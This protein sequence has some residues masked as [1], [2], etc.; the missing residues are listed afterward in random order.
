MATILNDIWITLDQAE[1]RAHLPQTAD[2]ADPDLL[3][4][5]LDAFHQA[6]QAQGVFETIGPELSPLPLGQADS[7]AVAVAATLGPE[8]DKLEDRPWMK[9]VLM[10]GL[11]QLEA[12]LN[13]RIKKRLALRNLFL[14]QPV[15][16]GGPA[17]PELTLDQVLD[18]LGKNPL[19]LEVRGDHLFP[20]WS[21]AY[22]YP[23][24]SSADQVQARACASCQKDCALRK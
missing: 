18:L 10:A 14:G 4:P 17:G 23:V 5:A 1:V 12:F 9:Q 3:Q 11:A 16:P 24:S 7:G 15:V 2:Q 8:V 21:L 13:Y 22:L 19:G 6:R 20:P